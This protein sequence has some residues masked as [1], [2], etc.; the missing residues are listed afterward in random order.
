MT[1]SKRASTEGSAPRGRGAAAAAWRPGSALYLLLLLIGLAAGFW[2]ESIHV[3]KSDLRPA[4]LP[5]LQTVALAQVAYIFLVH[6]LVIFRRGQ[7]GRTR[8]YWGSCAVESLAMLVAGVPF[9]VAAGWFADATAVDGIRTALAVAAFWPVAWSAGAWLR[10]RRGPRSPV[11]IFLV[12]AAFGPPAAHYILREFVARG[13]AFEWLWHLG[14][15]TFVWSNGAS[16]IP[17]WT[18]LP[19]WAVVFWIAVAVF[20]VLLQQLFWSDRS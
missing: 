5:A 8:N 20:G 12:L 17:S 9:Y 6:P 10:S 15:A 1:S 16:R 19:V 11:M 7:P 14:P 2:P 3:T 18:P 4:P 13:R